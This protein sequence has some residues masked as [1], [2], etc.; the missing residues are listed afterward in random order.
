MPIL[1]HFAGGSSAVIPDSFKHNTFDAKY[2]FMRKN[3]LK[4]QTNRGYELIIIKI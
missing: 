3:L 2:N 1:Y 4:L